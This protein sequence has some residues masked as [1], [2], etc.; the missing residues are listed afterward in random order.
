MKNQFLMIF[1]AL[2]FTANL[3][4]AWGTKCCRRGNLSLFN[5]KFSIRAIAGFVDEGFLFA[6]SNQKIKSHVVESQITSLVWLW[7]YLQKNN[8]R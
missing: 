6:T 7:Y 3:V 1:N 5:K 2:F 8:Q 4:A